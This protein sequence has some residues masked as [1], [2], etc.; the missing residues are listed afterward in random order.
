MSI[1]QG[2]DIEK[3][4]KKINELI[5]EIDKKDRDINDLNKEIEN[6]IDS[7]TTLKIEIRNFKSNGKKEDESRK[8]ELI[9][10]K[11]EIKV[12]RRERDHYKKIVKDNDL[13]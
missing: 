4:S 9:D 13:L 11:K 7:I 2:E 8:D 10:M 5:K 6:H 1:K 12:L 3:Q